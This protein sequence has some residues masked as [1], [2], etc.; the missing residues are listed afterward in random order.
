MVLHNTMYESFFSS[1]CNASQSFI[2]QNK[3]FTLQA[4]KRKQLIPPLHSE[5]D[6]TMQATRQS[7]LLN[8]ENMYIF[9]KELT[10]Q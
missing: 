5:P 6:F 9:S 1:V 3:Y 7:F 4:P 8:F 2:I 10:L